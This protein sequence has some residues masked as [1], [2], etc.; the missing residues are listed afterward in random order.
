MAYEVQPYRLDLFRALLVEHTEAGLAVVNAK[1]QSRY[2]EHYFANLNA[3]T[4]VVEAPYIDHDYLD[5][6]AAYY[7]RC[8]HPYERTCTRLHFF[9]DA[10]DD[11]LLT[12][13]LRGE[14][15]RAQ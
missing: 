1:L 12:G 6:F 14:L 13:L 5:D 15:D 7:V 3:Q 4:I 11:G 10:F 8:F 2:Y 9:T